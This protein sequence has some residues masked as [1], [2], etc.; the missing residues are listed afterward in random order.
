MWGRGQ[1]TH[2]AGSFFTLSP[3]LLGPS[4]PLTDSAAQGV[5]QAE[6][7]EQTKQRTK[8]IIQFKKCL[9][10]MFLKRDT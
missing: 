10:D 2:D 8:E 9:I 6:E 5:K 4:P 1:N 7:A 3:W